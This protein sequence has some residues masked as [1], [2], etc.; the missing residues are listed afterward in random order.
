MLMLNLGKDGKT[1]IPKK[2]VLDLMVITCMIL[3]PTN[4]FASLAA[5]PSSDTL[6]IKTAS[7]P[8]INGS[9]PFPPEIENPRP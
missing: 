8:S 5:G 9:A 3:S 4:N 1:I 6:E 2:L 7:D